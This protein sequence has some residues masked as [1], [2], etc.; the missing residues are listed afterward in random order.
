MFFCILDKNHGPEFNPD[1]FIILLEFNP[2]VRYRSGYLLE[3]IPSVEGAV[4]VAG[5][6]AKVI[7]GTSKHG[8]SPLG[9]DID[10]DP[11][12]AALEI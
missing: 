6:V 2:I 7:Q 9:R 4:A 11:S 8:L 12:T 5:L 10:L 3:D 1:H